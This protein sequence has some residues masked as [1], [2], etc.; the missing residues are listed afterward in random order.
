MRGVTLIE[1]VV[2]SLIALF[3][4]AAAVSFA[5][6]E[7]KLLGFSTERLEMQQ[8]SRSALDLMANDL[9]LAGAGIGY[10]NASAFQGLLFGRFV[11]NGVTFNPG[12]D[13]TTGEPAAVIQLNRS[14]LITGAA[15]AAAPYA[16]GTEDI[17]IQYANGYFGTIT[18][19]QPGAV[20]GTY[21][22]VPGIT[23]RPGERSLIRTEDGISTRSVRF[24]NQGATGCN[25]TGW[26]QP[27]STCARGIFANDIPG[28]QYVSG[29]GATGATG[30]GYSGGELTTGFTTQVYFVDSSDPAN[31]N[32]GSLRRMTFDERLGQPGFVCPGRNSTCGETVAANVE[33]LQAEI[34]LWDG[35]AV[36]GQWTRFT[37][38]TLDPARAATLNPPIPEEDRFMKARIRVDLELIIRMRVPDDRPRPGLQSAL[39]PL[40]CVPNT[41]GCP[42][43]AAV[44]AVERRSYR[45]SV[46]LKNG[47]RMQTIRRQNTF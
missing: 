46:E 12:V 43:A 37:G 20:T 44:D 28:L 14:D 18:D 30:A 36:P 11:V 27:P 24:W 21:C 41:Q 31:P 25:D 1:L 10:N 17:G 6:H 16:M 13:P 42:S 7:T 38:N 22:L 5:R 45:T 47:G 3:L 26:C 40:I 9:R 39:N 15:V 33:T 34:W 8:A 4:T 19:L 2:G 29:A 23:F 35:D 32:M